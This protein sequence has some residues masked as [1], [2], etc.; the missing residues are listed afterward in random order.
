MLLKNI[1]TSIPL[2]EN[3]PIMPTLFIGHGSPMNAIEENE[4]SQKWKA[5]SESL[6]LPS[7][8]VSISAHWE[9]KGTYVTATPQ[10]DTIYDF[11]GFPDELYKQVY[12]AKGD[13][14]LAKEITDTVKNNLVREDT[15]WGL[16]HGTW[17]VLKHLF[18]QANIPVIQI[19][20]N[21]NMTPQQHV[22]IAKELAFL[23]TKG[24][25]VIGS[26]NM[27]HNLQMLKVK[28]N[29][30]NAEYGY[31]WALEL[32]EILK[33]RIS[34]KDVQSLIEYQSLHRYARLA[35]PTL[36]HYLPMLYILGMM[37]HNEEIKFF[38]DKVIAGALN[39]T[40]FTV[41]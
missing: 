15:R 17:S 25:L 29:D 27:I 38:N 1:Q 39:M 13:P 30:F 37:Q 11:Y 4:F 28:G 20:L 16:D 24:V 5:L 3:T 12:P 31:D 18:P 34:D 19:S 32:N 23:R 21:R 33:K 26:G 22:E 41:G 2:T 6:P 40:S 9:T 35:I 10:P 8:I 14:E 7:A 36:E